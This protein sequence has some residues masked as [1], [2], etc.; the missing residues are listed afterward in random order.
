M[1]GT[2]ILQAHRICHVFS[3]TSDSLFDWDFSPSHEIPHALIKTDTSTDESVSALNGDFIPL[4]ELVEG[5]LSMARVY[6][7]RKAR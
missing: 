6:A 4:L 5:D 2:S 3:N 7:V 1:Q